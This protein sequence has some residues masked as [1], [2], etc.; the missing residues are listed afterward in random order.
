MSASFMRLYLYSIRD[1]LIFTLFDGVS[2]EQ[3]NGRLVKTEN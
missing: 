3:K 2:L 1:I